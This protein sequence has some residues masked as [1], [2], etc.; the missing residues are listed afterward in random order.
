[1]RALAPVLP[2]RI[3]AAL[4]ALLLALV[5]VTRA[6]YSP[7]TAVSLLALAGVP[8]ASAVV[9]ISTWVCLRQAWRGL[10]MRA[11]P[12]RL[13]AA[14]LLAAW[15]FLS[16]ALLAAWGAAAGGSQLLRTD[17]DLSAVTGKVYVAMVIPFVA[18]MLLTAA[19]AIAQAFDVAASIVVSVLGLLAALVIA[20]NEVLVSMS[21]L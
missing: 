13:T 4:E 17:P 12:A 16:A 11:A 18:L 2:W 15:G 8:V 19:F 3:W 21:N 14:A 1:M 20:G 10:L 5:A 6:V 9:G 7:S